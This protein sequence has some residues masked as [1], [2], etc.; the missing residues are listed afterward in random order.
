MLFVVDYA[1]GF[2]MCHFLLN[3]AAAE[4]VAA[5]KYADGRTDATLFRLDEDR[6]FMHF[7][8]QVKGIERLM[9]EGSPPWPV[10]RTLLTSGILDAGLI[11]K[12][13]GGKRLD[14]PRLD[15]RYSTKW[16]WEPPK[17][18]KAASD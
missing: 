18:L 17:P 10:E 9:H 15:V 3:G 6:P 5:W 13:D 11:S 16:N 7:A 14:T 1:D 12:R 2:R 8:H 4:F